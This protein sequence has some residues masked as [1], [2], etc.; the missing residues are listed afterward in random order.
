MIKKTLSKIGF[1][2]CLA[3]LW[4]IE[5]GSA[6]ETP[7][8]PLIPT[9][10]VN[11]HLKTYSPDEIDLIHADLKNILE[12]YFR[13]QRAVSDSDRPVYVAT[14]GGPGASKSTILE[15]Y[16][17]THPGFVYADPDPGALK[18]MI[19]T[20]HQSLTYYDISQAPSYA[21]LLKSAYEKWRPASNYIACTILN[22]AFSKRYNIAH[23][24]TSTAPQVEGLYD[25]LKTQNYK[26]VLLLCGSTDENRIASLRHRAKEM[27][28]IQNS[29][30][31]TISK[32]K[33]FP[34]R[35]PIY[36]K[37]AD[38][39]IFYW[40]SDFSRGNVKAATLTKKDGLITHDEAAYKNFGLQYGEEHLAQWV[41]NF[42]K[43]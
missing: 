14:A 6:I 35:F 18:L 20:Y 26:I 13:G 32:G 19:N 28:F 39:I 31:D 10:F 29:D 12:L 11:S 36:F 3:Y 27:A 16:L 34:E 33:A 17:K 30:E 40:T 37:K 2:A 9:D 5:Q 38:E 25:T 42:K 7:S 8:L 21:A 22:E 23:G 41:E 1:F 15:T 24:T 4:G 43:S